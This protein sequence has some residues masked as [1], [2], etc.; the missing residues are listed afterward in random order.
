MPTK[1]S[2]KKGG[3]FAYEKQFDFPLSPCYKPKGQPEIP[4]LGW[5]AG[6]GAS[7]DAEPTVSQMGVID[8]PL[9][10]L[11]SASE[12]AW[13]NRYTQPKMLRGGDNTNS[14]IIKKFNETFTSIND[15]QALRIN[16]N[17]GDE[18]YKMVIIYNPKFDKKYVLSIA[19]KNSNSLI[20]TNN[21]NEV[22]G[23]IKNYNLVSMT[24]APVPAAATE[25]VNANKQPLIITKE[26][27]E[28][29]VPAVP[30]GGAKKKKKKTKKTRK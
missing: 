18:K 25:V 16:A 10:N 20:N 6:G 7:C 26:S 24:N 14:N 4:R 27:S 2:K 8:K 15:V 13:D 9:N 19:S 29:N 5:H 28:G 23:K 30:G 22:I 11:P 21:R 17:K 12:L 3:A 1:S